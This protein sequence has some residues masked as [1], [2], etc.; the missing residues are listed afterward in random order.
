RDLCLKIMRA[1]IEQLER[2]AERDR[3]NFTG[4][5]AD[6]IVAPP[7][8]L[9]DPLGGDTIMALFAKYEAANP[10]AIRP[11]T[12]GQCRR[13]VQHFADFVGPSVR[14]TMIE[15]RHVRDWK[16]LLAEFP[17]KAAE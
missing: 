10:N 4:K 5:P 17:V 16:E 9:P 6:P 14:G 11:E 7:A 2:Y 3:G 15:R 12:M 1:E 13:D 8:N